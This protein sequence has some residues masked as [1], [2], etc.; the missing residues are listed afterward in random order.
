MS[1][2]FNVCVVTGS[3]AD[4]GLIRPV[5]E[6]ILKSVNLQL[7]IIVTGSH[8]SKRFGSTYH[9]IEGDGFVIDRKVE[10]LLSVDSALAVASSMNN[11]LL[12]MVNSFEEIKPDLILVLG[13][14][15]EILATAQAAML[16]QIPVAHMCGGD[17]ASGTYDNIIRHC[18]TKI[19]SLHFVT[20]SEALQR[21]IQLGENPKKVFCFGSTCVDN[22]N[23]LVLFDKRVLEVNLNTTLKEQIFVVTF[24][25]LTMALSNGICDLNNALEVIKRKLRSNNLTVIFTK[26]NADNGGD[27]ITAILEKFVAENQNTKLFDSLGATTYLSLVKHASLVI[28]NSSSGIYEAP[29]LGTAT[30]D[31]GERQMLRKA[32]NSVFRCI[33]TRESIE[34]SISQAVVYDFTNLELIYGKGK[35]SDQIVEV[36]EIEIEDK[37]LSV[38]KFFDIDF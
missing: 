17:I 14:R 27:E 3:R 23:S 30:V 22:V 1:K 9:E 25:P 34:D 31:V 36:L 38:K 8:L 10:I 33:G 35:T 20:H 7:Q 19:S 11:C 2:K 18:I 21:V 5:M 15:T 6:K 16:C 24:H 26:A 29:Y 4:Y 28:G 13:D 12:G 37:N 32:P